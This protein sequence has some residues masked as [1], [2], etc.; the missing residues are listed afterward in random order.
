MPAT[1]F[2][3]HFSAGAKCRAYP[4]FNH[5]N[6][7][8]EGMPPKKDEIHLVRHHVSSGMFGED[9]SLSHHVDQSLLTVSVFSRQLMKI[10]QNVANIK[11]P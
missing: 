2:M 8:E 6:R 1:R 11:A 10:K 3:K 9:I 7:S 4:E 5:P